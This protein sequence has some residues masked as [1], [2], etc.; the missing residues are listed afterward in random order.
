LW[1]CLDFTSK[2]AGLPGVRLGILAIVCEKR[3]YIV[4]EFNR[5][6]GACS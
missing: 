1:R 2:S 3:V 6:T 4:D 5:L